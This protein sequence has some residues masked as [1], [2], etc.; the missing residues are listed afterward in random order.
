[1]TQAKRRFVDQFA[2]Y[3]ESKARELVVTAIAE[4]FSEDALDKSNTTY[5][6]ARE[7]APKLCIAHRFCDPTTEE[8]KQ[9]AVFTDSQREKFWLTRLSGSK[10]E[11]ILF[12]CGDDHIESFS[13][14]LT[15]AGYPNQILSRRWGFELQYPKVYWSNT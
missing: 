15:K 12:I 8:R 4:E 10:E 1:M 2:V 9:H 5:C 13:K 14:R 7:V 6:T 3:L 11:D